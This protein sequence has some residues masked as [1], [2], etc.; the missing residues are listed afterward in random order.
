MQTN[1]DAIVIGS[2]IGGLAAAGVLARLGGKRV[3][4]LEK[5]T[6]RG[7]L[8]HVFRRDGASWD[9]GLHY[10]DD[11]GPGQTTRRLFDYLTDHRLEW[12][13]L[14]D[15]YDHFSYP[16]CDFTVPSDEARYRNGLISRFPDEEQGIRRY[17]SDLHTAS[18]WAALSIAEPALPRPL[19][20]ALRAWRRLTSGL[21]LS[22]TRDVL[23][24]RIGSPTL[25]ALLASQWGDYGLPPGTSAF[26]THALVTTG[27]FGGAW[28]PKG[29][30]GRI[31]RGIEPS[32]E[33]AGGGVLIGHEATG[34]LVEGGRAIGVRAVD[35]R[36]PQ[37]VERTLRAPLVISDAGAEP[38]FNR[39]LPT[40]GPVGEATAGIRKDLGGLAPVASAV[41]VYLRLR[42]PASSL[43]VDG[44]NHWINLDGDHDD[45]AGQG[46]AVLDGHPR[47]AFLS[48][49]SAKSGDDRFHTAEIIALVPADLFSD[50]EGTTTRERGPRYEQFKK[51]IADGLIALADHELPGLAAL[52]SYQEVST[53]LSVEHYT[54]HPQGRFYG[55]AGVP[56]RYRAGLGVGTPV[57]GLLLS[58]TD[59]ASLGIHGALM[60]G[61][62]AASRA[63]G[64]SAYPRLMKRIGHS[65]ADDA[66]PAEASANG[67]VGRHR[68]V[69]ERRTACS[70][71]VWRLSL[72]LDESL[73]F[74]PGQYVRLKVAPMEWRDYSVVAAGGTRIDLLVST[75]TGG[76]GSRFASTAPLGTATALEGPLGSYRL[77]ESRGMRVFVATGTGLAPL[78]PMFARL[79]E[80]GQLSEARLLFGC[81][82]RSEDLTR[83]VDNLPGNTRVCVSRG[84]PGPD[85]FA[86]RVTAAL[87]EL[88][89][90]PDGTDVYVC[91]SASMVGDVTAILRG[92]DGVRVFTEP[93]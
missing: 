50:W 23:E 79:G 54:S 58:G 74:T 9:V 19:T 45:L 61:V 71:T 60:G 29:G 62:L 64:P 81:R 17:F 86:G 76:D 46:R 38:T 87:A 11:A 37:P 53:P 36:G 21:P 5:H 30:A 65:A 7:G 59:A 25:R 47:R 88:R 75:R 90:A 52:V 27:Y 14:P 13:R 55:V 32:I 40:D 12:N 34:I 10:V 4:V 80:L 31:A 85:G 68:A 82:D 89:F 28:F 22:T 6:E 48:F 43:G 83:D 20:A 8:T 57:S 51:R 39:L 15:G 3:L 91:G 84:D 73:G 1:W 16:G 70:P 69:L 56:G 33:A 24:R 72:R 41:T 35:R 44:E 92:R 93:Y 42:A 49:P 66:G 18:R 77:R 26:A 67:L 63:L 78:I 2:G